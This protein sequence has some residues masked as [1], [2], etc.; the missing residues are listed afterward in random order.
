MT[1]A[2][3]QILI[4]RSIAGDRAA[5]GE[6]YRRYVNAMYH[7]AVRIVAEPAIAKDLTQDVFIKVFQE[8]KKYRGEATLGAWIKRITVNTCLSFLKKQGRLHKEALNEETFLIPDEV[9]NI[10]TPIDIKVIHEAIKSLPSGCRTVLSL[11]LL[12]GYRHKEIAGILNISESTS[13]SQYHRGKH[14]LKENLK[15]IYQNES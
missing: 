14:L 13:K 15:S 1:S 4:K 3:D 10:E 8:L 12:E 9:A 6:L 5:Q 7:T 11:F 2:E